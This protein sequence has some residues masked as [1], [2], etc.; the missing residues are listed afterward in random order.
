MQVWVTYSSESG[1]GS[2]CMYVCNS[3]STRRQALAEVAQPWAVTLQGR[4]RLVV[5]LPGVLLG[6][7][8][9]QGVAGI[10]QQLAIVS[11]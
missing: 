6:T 9:V 2:F 11:C 1:V 4:L 5:V 7:F 10:V 8:V 3:Y